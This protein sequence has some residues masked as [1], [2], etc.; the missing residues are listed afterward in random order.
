MVLRLTLIILS[1]LLLQPALAG[2]YVDKSIITFESGQALRQDVIISNP[3]PDPAFVEIQVLEVTSPGEQD[4]SRTV[5][6]DP[7]RIGLIASP[8]RLMIP[9]GTQRAVRLVSLNGFQDTEQ[10]YRVNVKPVAGDVKSDKMAVMVLVTYQ[11]LVFVEPDKIKVSLESE[12]NGSTLSLHNAGNVN[13]MLYGGIQCA[14]DQEG[15]DRDAASASVEELIN[16]ESIEDNCVEVESRR[17]YPGNRATLTL[18]RSAPVTFK[19]TAAGETRELV[20]D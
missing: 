11:L 19:L 13:L 18:P 8:R 3:D 1:G 14:A 10:V 6:K 15:V 17:L 4:E 7:E 5:V 16:P 2:V 20:I 12:R 9:A